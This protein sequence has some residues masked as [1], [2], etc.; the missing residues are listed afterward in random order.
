MIKW[1]KD[2]TKQEKWLLALLVIS[3]V[4]VIA[5]WGFIKKE[6]GGAFRQRMEYFKQPDRRDTIPK[7]DTLPELAP[8]G[9]HII[10]DT[11]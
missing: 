7:Q 2:R 6:A 8:A 9:R 4:A 5:R 10:R 11:V 3:L 1:L